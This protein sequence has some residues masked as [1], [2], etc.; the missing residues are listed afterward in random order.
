[1]SI[2][3]SVCD[4]SM[5]M[6]TLEL[7]YMIFC[8]CLVVHRFPIRCASGSRHTHAA[9]KVSRLSLVPT[10]YFG[11]HYVTHNFGHHDDVLMMVYSGSSLELSPE[12]SYLHLFPKITFLR[13]VHRLLVYFPTRMNDSRK[14][15]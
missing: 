12:K 4:L 13:N 15:P 11:G 5:G 10:S 9:Y 8:R 14:L 3:S 1:M 7:V 2:I 6:P